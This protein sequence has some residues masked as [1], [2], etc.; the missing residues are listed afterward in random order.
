[1]Q[2]AAEE[3]LAILSSGK[4]QRK[5]GEKKKTWNDVLQE[6][7]LDFGSLVSPGKASNG[8]NGQDILPGCT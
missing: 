4:D 7:H 3:K 1:M 2:N 5:K 8:S 6:A